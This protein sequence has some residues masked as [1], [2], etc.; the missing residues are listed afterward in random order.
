MI[1]RCQ[2][3]WLLGVAA[4]LAAACA[5]KAAAPPVAPAAP[6]EA[7]APP[8]PTTLAERPFTLPVATEGTLSNGLRVKVV[9]NHEVPFVWVHLTLRAGEW[10]NPPGK[11]WLASV[12]MDMLNE[13]A[14]GRDAETIS[15]DLRRLGS[16]VESYAGEDDSGVS[17]QSLTRN[18]A[19]TLDLF[20]D[21]VTRPTFPEAEWAVL[22]P[23]YLDAIE[24]ARSDAGTIA[25]R[26][27]DRVLHGQTYKGRLPTAAGVKSLK[28]LDMM[29]WHKANVRPDQALL[30]VGGD[31]TLAEVQPLLEARLGAWKAPVGPKPTV[32]SPVRPAPAPTAITVVDKPGSTQSVVKVA[33]YVIA[34]T[35][36]DWSALVLANQVV[37]GQFTA[38]L[39]MNL[40][41]AKGWTYGTRG[42]VT[43]DLAGGAW[44][45]G[46]NIHLEHT[47][48]ALSEMRREFA[49]PTSDRPLTTDELERARGALVNGYPLRFE[50]A[51]YLLSQEEAVFHYGLPADWV[52]SWMPRMKA[53]TLEAAQAAWAARIDGN[54]MQFVVVGDLA[55]IR[56]DLEKLGLP[57]LERD[58]DGNL[59]GSK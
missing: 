58:V 46:G 15:R 36:T 49:G 54:H 22:Q 31:T 1:L 44:S 28:V 52:T 5:P 30:L 48:A 20:A 41:E 29:A 16:S 32:R 53:V 38:R 11:E 39:N 23:Q 56:T 12:T 55:K 33:A 18:L 43:Y 6:A 59:V 3:N 57:V 8:T 9:E 34:P 37:D 4:V 45:A 17:C 25:Q 24:S 10:S 26:V 7:P 42:S 47:A 14:G 13:G 19:P 35:D 51:G 2:G 27:L 40:R 21:V 50:N